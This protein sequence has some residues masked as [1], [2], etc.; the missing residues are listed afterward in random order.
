MSRRSAWTSLRLTPIANQFCPRFRELDR[1]TTTVHLFKKKR[2][3][4]N[5]EL[6]SEETRRRKVRIDGDRAMSMNKTSFI[7]HN[8]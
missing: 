7:V 2:E 5:V 1:K 6:S 4:V 3:L 8:S